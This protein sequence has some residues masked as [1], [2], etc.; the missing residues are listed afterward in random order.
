LEV[1]KFINIKTNKP[2]VVY[3][4]ILSGFLK[5]PLF[6]LFD[7]NTIKTYNNPIRDLLKITKR[8]FIC[9]A[10]TMKVV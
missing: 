4:K 9:D 7:F 5:G 3:P 6:G 8:R 2:N 1:R 10:L